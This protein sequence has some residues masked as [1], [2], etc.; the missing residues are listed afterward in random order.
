[1]ANDIIGGIP[2]LLS[3]C[4]LCGAA[5][6]YDG[7]SSNEVTYTFGSSGFLYQSNKLMYDRQTHTL[8]NQLTGE[9]VLGELVDTN[10]KLDLL[11]VVLTTWEE[12]KSKHPETVVLDLNTGYSRPYSTGA[13][14]GDYFA[15]KETMFPVWQRSDLLAAKQ[16][17]YALTVEG[18]P[19]AYPIDVLAM[20]KVINDK[21]GNTT[22]LLVATNGILTV[23]GADRM[24]GQ[25]AYIVG[26]EVRAYDRKGKTFS[27]GLDGNTV[28]DENS[29]S[30]QITEEALIGYGGEMLSRINGHLAY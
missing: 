1:M 5:I 27:L 16:Q 15:S 28:L 21:I 14:Y 9:P 7:R 25:Q 3:Y 24:G 23:S 22:I 6:A 4:T 12:W 29:K 19:K 20:E 18:V 13:A 11:P 2:V 26:S 30:W 17:I 10:I 8:W